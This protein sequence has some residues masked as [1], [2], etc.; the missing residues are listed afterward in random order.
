MPS[1]GD[2]RTLAA[3]DQ[4]GA[5]VG[6]GA[7][8]LANALNPATI[9][10]SG[11]FAAVGEHMRPAIEAR[12]QAGVLAPDAGG[13]RVEFSTLGFT[14][15][16]RGGAQLAL[17]AI[18][19][20]PTRVAPRSVAEGA[21]GDRDPDEPTVHHLERGRPA[22]DDRHRQGV[23]R[24]PRARRRGSRRP[25]RRGALPARANGAGKSTLIKVLSGFHQP[26]QGTITWN[27]EEASF[28]TPAKAIE[29]GVATI[30]QELDLVPHLDVTENV[31]LGHEV[32]R[33]G[34]SQRRQARKQVRDLLARLGHSEISP[35]RVVG[36]LSPANQQ[37][38]SMARALSRDTRLLVLDEPSAVLDQEEV[39]NL[40]RV[41]RDLTAEGVAV[42]YIFHRLEE[43]REI[44]DRITVLKDGRTVGVGLAVV[45]TPT[46]DLIK[47][48]TGRAIEYVFP[49]RPEV[50]RS[51]TA[52]TWSSTSRT[53]RCPGS[54]MV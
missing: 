54:S 33:V 52:A 25:R 35:T 41:I 45:D 10:L 9:V 8:V 22:P 21:V 29:H 17:D 39:T 15:A 23:P 49:P 30:Y 16:V 1:L 2:T 27:G 4:V 50:A 19:A 24:R 7:A 34:L 26:D 36:D 32:S 11:Y 40:F 37:I 3:L 12:L 31:Y 6:V 28:S 20:D 44:G 48:M 42:V 53:W 18:F 51:A 43:I 13:T 46:P 14:A 38:V 47:L 5:W